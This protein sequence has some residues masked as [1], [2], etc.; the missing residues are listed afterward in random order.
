MNKLRTVENLFPIVVTVSSG[1]QTRGGLTPLKEES[2]LDSAAAA[3]TYTIADMIQGYQYTSYLNSLMS[4]R[5][6]VCDVVYVKKLMMV[7]VKKLMN[8][9]SPTSEQEIRKISG[10]E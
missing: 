7:Y 5:N 8:S 10:S 2:R 6:T 4:G 9:N 1:W 3:D